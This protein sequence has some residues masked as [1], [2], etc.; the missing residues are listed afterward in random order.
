MTRNELKKFLAYL[1]TNYPIENCP[2]IKLRVTS[3]M[4]KGTSVQ[5]RSAFGELAITPTHLQIAVYTNLADETCLMVLAH[6][7]RHVLQYVAL[8]W[9]VQNY[10]EDTPERQKEIEADADQWGIKISQEY[11]KEVFYPELL[12]EV[13]AVGRELFT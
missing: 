8:G 1:Q 11:L 4:I 10:Y 3:R 13:E 9:D 12:A 7:Y 5:C 2:K 6:E